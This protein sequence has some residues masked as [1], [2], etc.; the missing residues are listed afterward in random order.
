MRGCALSRHTLGLQNY[1][2]QLNRIE[3]R[4]SSI[5]RIEPVYS[6]N[7]EHLWC[8]D[9]TWFSNSVYKREEPHHCIEVVPWFSST[10]NE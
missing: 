5:V 8:V 10:T 1:P 4:F 2:R 9:S 7:E 3:Q 6:A